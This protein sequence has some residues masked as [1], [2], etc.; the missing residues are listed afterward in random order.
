VSRNQRRKREFAF[1]V[2]DAA[3]ASSEPAIVAASRTQLPHSFIGEQASI[4]NM[5][6]Q[7]VR[8]KLLPENSNEV[9]QA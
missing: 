8:V 6:P 3:W 4:L 7:E 2:G 9:H 5:Q 1:S